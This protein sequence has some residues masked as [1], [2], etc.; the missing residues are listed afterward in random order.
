MKPVSRKIS[1][2]PQDELEYLRELLA[3]AYDSPR[4]KGVR[5]IMRRFAKGL[6]VTP[7]KVIMNRVQVAKVQ[8]DPAKE[9]AA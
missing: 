6:F 3:H 9:D 8:K 2:M 5:T 4:K 7:K 1:E